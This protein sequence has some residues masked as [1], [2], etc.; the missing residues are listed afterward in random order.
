[1]FTF[2]KKLFDFKIE[3]H[4]KYRNCQESKTIKTNKVPY[5]NI[6]KVYQ[7]CGFEIKVPMDIAG[8]LDAKRYCISLTKYKGQ[9]SCVQL[10]KVIDGKSTYIGTLKNFMNVQSFKDGNV[11]NFNYNNLIYKNEGE[12]K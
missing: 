1:M 11:C 2:L 8:E 5:P 7:R 10:S 9:P 4:C 3:C 12:N 6:E